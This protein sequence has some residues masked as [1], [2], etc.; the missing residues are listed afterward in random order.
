M[1][2]PPTGGDDKLARRAS[3]CSFQVID[4]AEVSVR[5]TACWMQ[6]AVEVEEQDMSHGGEILQG[7][8]HGLPFLLLNFLARRPI[9]GMVTAVRQPHPHQ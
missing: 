2:M 9:E 5:A 6:D 4:T 1:V 8:L 3:E 7:T